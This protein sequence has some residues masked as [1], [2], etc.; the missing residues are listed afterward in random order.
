MTPSKEW[1]FIEKEIYKD[2]VEEN[3]ELKEHMQFYYK[4]CKVLKEENEKLV[5]ALEAVQRVI[6]CELEAIK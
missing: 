1:H 3:E 2:L 5:L 6:D 4:A